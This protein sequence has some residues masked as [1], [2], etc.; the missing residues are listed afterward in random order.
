MTQASALPL[1][2]HPA[3]ALARDLLAAAR[4][5]PGAATDSLRARLDDTGVD[6]ETTDAVIAAVQESR[7]HTA[8]LRQRAVELEALFSTARDLVRLQDVDAVL[9]RLVERAHEL[10][11]TDV[12]YLSEREPETSALRV[13][14]SAGTVTPEFR[15]LLVPSGIGLASRIARTREP[16]WV[17][18][19][20]TMQE[21]PH[22]ASIDAAVAGEGL[23]AFLGV[24]LAVGDEVLG[25]LFA[26]NRFAHDFTPEEVLL[27]SAFADH[28]AAVLHSARVIAERAAA[29][30]RAEDAYRRLEAH[31]AATETA[32]AIH[33]ELI[34]AVISGGSVAELVTTLSRHLGRRVWALS[35]DGRPLFAHADDARRLP[36]RS[37]IA[38][39]AARSQASGHAEPIAASGRTWL[40]TAIIGADR[41]VGSILAESDGALPDDLPDDASR[42]TLERAGHVAALVSFRRDA[43]DALRA[44][45]RAA[46]LL[47]LID[48]RETAPEADP[49]LALP[50]PLAACAV[51]DVD[52]ADLAHAVTVAGEVVGDDGLVARRRDHVVVAWAVPDA[53]A[54]TE[55]LRHALADRLGDPHVSAVVA[56][57][58]DSG[59]ASGLARAGRDLAFLPSLGLRG[60]TARSDAFAP[61]HL[62]ASQDAGA[63]ERFV[64]DLIGP[65]LRWDAHRGTRLFE[66]LCAFFDAGEQGKDAAARLRV[67]K[68]TLR[69]RLDRIEQLL[70][71]AWEDPELRFRVHA[72]VRLERLRRDLRAPHAGT[73]A[74]IGA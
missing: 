30:D 35:A 8:H 41:V 42:R 56:P 5:A 36:P 69:Q 6:R 60:T 74:A 11:G 29:T 67:H 14:H 20:A 59:L 70:P 49:Q 71:G 54:R 16:T 66:T 38:D 39:A 55:R 57:L 31:L 53:F 23:V 28:A 12:T 68:N 7:L 48:G 40:I 3:G 47:D 62:L 17:P 51:V 27:L 65:V 73:T 43:V 2:P 18:R 21:A 33:E 58:S 50:A 64:A 52:G 10:M 9:R 13:R 72:A 63:A 22:H 1:S 44:E 19:Y 34:A 37:L 45:R 32:S 61:Y 15:D 25:V 46:H 4:A 24:P 26:C